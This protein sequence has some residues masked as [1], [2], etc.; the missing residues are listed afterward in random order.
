MPPTALD[1]PI[2]VWG[3]RQKEGAIAAVAAPLSGPT[4]ADSP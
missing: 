2:N 4:M 1:Q 3:F